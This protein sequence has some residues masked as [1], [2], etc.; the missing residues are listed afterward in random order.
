MMD[1]I[2]NAVKHPFK[3]SSGSNGYGN[4]QQNADYPYPNYQ[5]VQLTESLEPRN[6]PAKQSSLLDFLKRRQ[7]RPEQRSD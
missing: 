4:I 6:V 3:F 5:N 7:R 1:N 2:K